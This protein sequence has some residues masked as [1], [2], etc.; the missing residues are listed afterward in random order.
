MGDERWVPVVRTGGDLGWQ[1]GARRGRRVHSQIMSA[2]SRNAA[3]GLARE[4][5]EKLNGE[6]PD[7]PGDWEEIHP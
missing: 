3:E 5:A 7:A 4:L 2:T 1:A 6:R